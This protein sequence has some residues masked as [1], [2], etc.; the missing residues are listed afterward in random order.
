MVVGKRKR[1]ET[2]YP[3]VAITVGNP[4]KIPRAVSCLMQALQGVQQDEKEGHCRIGSISDLLGAELEDMRAN[5]KKFQSAGDLCRGIAYIKFANEGVKPSELVHRLLEDESRP[6]PPF[7]SR[8]IPFDYVSHPHY[9][10]ATGIVVREIK[11]FFEGIEKSTT[12]TLK[13]SKHA[14]S[15]V[16]KSKLLQVMIE[17]IPDRHEPTVMGAEWTILVDVTPVICGISIVR[18]YEKFCEYNVAK[19]VQQRRE[20]GEEA[21][22]VDDEEP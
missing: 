3:G 2:M 21:D 5:K 18:D 11:P 4:G 9:A 1:Y 13:Y 8:I 15:S 7:I 16:D 17:Q 20:Q 12:W 14:M 19:L 10:D 6:L 22:E